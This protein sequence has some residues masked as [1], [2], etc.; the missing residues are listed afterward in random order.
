MGKLSTS[1]YSSTLLLSVLCL[2][3]VFALYY[4]VVLPKKDEE[5][6]LQQSVNV[7]QTEVTD[8]QGRIALIQQQNVA[9]LENT[10]ALR[11]KVPQSR[12]MQELLLAI[13]E[14]EYVSDSKMLTVSF[15]NYDSL[16]MS[17][18]LEDPSVADEVVVN[19]VQADAGTE[20]QGAGT[21]EVPVEE[22]PVSSVMREN[23]P[24]ELKM[25]TFSMNFEA[26]ERENIEAFVKE[27]EQLE[28]VMRIDTINYNLLGEA[29]MLAE[30][31]VDLTTATV[32][33]TTFYYEGES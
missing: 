26:P 9:A 13:E 20:E 10:Y 28:R 8:L 19:D 31:P 18:S 30:N 29:D 15:N 22:V 4:Y 5:K 11:K 2:A 17:S 6:Q 24:P 25:V 21:T 3:L 16:V 12:M 33:V 7:L 27:L 23:L 32:Q 14:I 1:R